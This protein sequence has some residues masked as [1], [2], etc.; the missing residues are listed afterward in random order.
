MGRGAQSRLLTITSMAKKDKNPNPR[1]GKV[2]KD[3]DAPATMEVGAPAAPEFFDPVPV[4]ERMNAYW[5]KGAGEQYV[6]RTND[7]RWGIWNQQATVDRMIKVAHQMGQ[8]LNPKRYEGQPLSQVR[9][10][11]M[12]LREERGLDEVFTALPGYREGVHVLPGNEERVLVKTSPRFVEPVAGE[13]PLIAAIFDGMLGT[14]PALRQKDYFF[15]WLKIGAESVMQG[16]PGDW[17]PG[18]AMIMA[19]PRG[20]GKSFV[21]EFV[22]R[23][24]FGGRMADPTK[25]LFGLDEFNA[26]SFAAE[27]LVLAEVPMPSQKTNDRVAFG[28]KIKQVVAN[29]MQRMRLMR[30][31]PWTVFPFWRLLISLNDEPDKLRNLPLITEDIGDKLVIMH[32]ARSGMPMP[33]RT[34]EDRRMFREAVAAEIPHFLHFLLHEFQVPEDLLVYDDG[35]DA[36][37]FGFREFH[38]PVIKG[39]LFDDTADAQFLG[40]IDLAEFSSNSWGKPRK[41][42]ELPQ[43][44]MNATL[45]EGRD[46]G[47]VWHERADTLQQLL[48]GEGECSCSVASIA[49]KMFAHNSCAR[50]LGRLARDEQVGLRVAKQDTRDWKGWRIARPGVG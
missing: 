28:E 35:S 27:L 5:K 43:G 8:F 1:R 3:G 12:H 20:C 18:H 39:A 4:V 29:T 38:H 14:E 22:V 6:L 33:T 48:T 23:P 13:W 7:G 26:D 10:V 21:Q 2:K 40:L 42:W 46:A 31:E 16:V 11:L 9:E 45:D 47:L 36:T 24:L 17:R 37:R 30:T 15:S 34:L 19:G 44:K 50:M 49:K 41:L 32:C 25:M